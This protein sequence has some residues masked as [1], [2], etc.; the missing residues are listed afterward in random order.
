MT[1]SL[2]K[3]LFL[4]CYLNGVYLKVSKFIAKFRK[5]RDYND[6]YGSYDRKRKNKNH[7][8]TKKLANYEYDSLLS[9]FSN[10]TDSFQK[11]SR[12]KAKNFY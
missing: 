1:I 11:T 12:R 8:S 9:D 5:E 7:N 10:E 3:R 2:S 4:K 6:D